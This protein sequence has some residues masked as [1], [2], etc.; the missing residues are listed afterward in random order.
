MN[1]SEIAAL[2]PL[3]RAGELDPAGAAA[4]AAHLADCPECARSLRE[5]E[6]L[7]DL[8]RGVILSEAVSTT[9]V[10][11]RVRERV[12]AELGGV[13]RPSLAVGSGPRWRIA[14][15][16]SVAALLLLAVAYRHLSGPHGVYADAAADHRSEVVDAHWRPW[17]TD[18]VAISAL[19]ERTGV[20]PRAVLALAPP[21]YHLARAKRCA[22]NGRP[23][24]HLV[25]SNGA[26]EFSAYLRPR[27]EEVLPGLN[28]KTKPG[29]LYTTDFGAE[30]LGCVQT[31]GLTAMIVTDE[32]AAAASDLARFAS[33]A[34][35]SPPAS[36]F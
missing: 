19:A 31:S 14:A 24:L 7:D 6:Q 28:G 13:P 12:A 22:L 2:A 23:F 25:Y 15:L 5:Q 9:A 30:H 26:Q 3:Y 21:G 1:C 32:S 35:G 33:N 4:F 34:L 18:P 36:N 29:A 27:D 8:L 16:A 10:D 11:R 17:L 20:A